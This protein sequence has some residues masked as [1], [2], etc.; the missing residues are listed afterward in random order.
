M[1]RSSA[2]R[3]LC[4]FGLAREHM[5]ADSPEASG[6]F[7]SESYTP[8]VITLWYR[9]PEL[10]LGATRYGPPVDIWSVGCILG[11]LLLHCPLLP[12]PTEVRQLEMICEL[13]G[14]PS[15]RIWPSVEQLPLWAQLRDCLPHNEYNELPTKFARVQP[16]PSALELVDA[17]LT[18]DPER[19]ITADGALAHQWLQSEHPLPAHA[20]TSIS[21]LG[22]DTHA[23]A[24]GGS[25]PTRRPRGDR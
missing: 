25:A 14:T 5:A 1:A 7:A 8:R 18:Y 9:C 23:Q 20:V 2:R 13:L 11:E 6:T 17:M 4:D 12:A 19:R 3:Q 15:A 21:T 10:L 22:R 16:S 24:D